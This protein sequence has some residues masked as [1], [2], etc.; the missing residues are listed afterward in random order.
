MPPYSQQL[1]SRPH[2]FADTAVFLSHLELDAMLRTVAAIEAAAR[3]PACRAQALDRAGA[4]AQQDFGLRGAF[5][6]Y[7][8]HL[9]PAGPQLIEVNTNAGG[10][11]LIA[12]LVRAQRV[13][14]GEVL[15]PDDF[16]RDVAA[17]FRAEWWLLGRDT[18]LR[19]VAIVDDSPE[20]QYLFP[21][22]L[23]ARHLLQGAGIDAVIADPSELVW[24]DGVLSLRGAPI[25]LVYNRLVDFAL[26]EPCHAAL[27][28]AYLSG[29]IAVTP[30]PHVH[31]LL[32][33]K[34]NLVALSHIEIVDPCVSPEVVTALEAVPE[35]VEV[36]AANASALWESRKHW[37]FKPA[38]GH[39]SKAVY[40]GDKITRGVWTDIVA[41][42]ARL[43]RDAGGYV[44]QAFAAP[45]ERMVT[46]DGVP[47]A[48]KVD[49]RL[50]TYDGRLL[51]AAA[52]IYQ[53]QATNFRTPGGGFAPLF[54]VPDHHVVC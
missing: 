12:A 9:T 29:A 15:A 21:E 42:S 22:F 6:G 45:S 13:C 20:Q 48:R 39:G 25:D 3:L 53:G 19:R 50:Y 10:A 1:E 36:A 4:V 32:A 14:C 18:P 41:P 17:M 33:D 47:Q 27:R 54:L 43:L 28:E 8:F 46:V 30:N 38:G 34:R 52:R 31:A 16:P 44:A 2:L 11:F 23:L 51:L 5:M 7:D 26:S 35:T 49:V 37:F 24:R 40:R